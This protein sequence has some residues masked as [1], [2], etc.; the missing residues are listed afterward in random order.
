MK[1]P[2]ESAED[3]LRRYPRIVA[4]LICE[5]LGYATPNSAAQILKDTKE[6]NENWCEWLYSCY[7]CDPK[8]PVRQAIQ[9]RHSHKGYMAEYQNAY[10]IVRRQLD[11]GQEPMFASW[12]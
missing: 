12:F 3:Y 6:G 11:S 2:L 7:N 5:S 8:I 4:H 9:R 10:A 1:K